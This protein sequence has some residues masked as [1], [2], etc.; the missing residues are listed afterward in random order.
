M[1][2]QSE[3]KEVLNYDPDTGIF[4]WKISPAPQVKQNKIAGS[5]TSQGYIVITINRKLYPAHRL[6]WLYVHGEM[7]KKFID[8][9]NTI[10]SDNKLSNLRD[11]SRIKNGQNQIKAHKNNISGFLG[12]T[13]Y[14][15]TKSWVA[16]IKNNGKLIHL[17][18]Y[19]NPELAYE[20]Y[21]CMKRKIHEGC[22][23]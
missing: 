13:W 5:L 3:L 18:Y 6:A 21:L 4:T 20:S 19:K 15:R 12:V 23:I 11:A 9:I 17:G 14:E 7:P 2:T 8:H 16:K 22:T 10:K 1:I